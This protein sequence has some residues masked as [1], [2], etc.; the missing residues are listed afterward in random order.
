MREPKF[1][2]TKVKSRPPG[3]KKQ[4]LT[5]SIYYP[6]GQ[7]KFSEEAV[8]K[9]QMEGK[10]IEFYCDVAKKTLAWILFDSINLTNITGKLPKVI[11]RTKAGY[12]IVTAKAIL[13]QLNITQAYKN[14][15]IK[16]Y[17]DT[18]M[19]QD[20]LYVRVRKNRFPL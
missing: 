13:S 16:K 15:P 6:S 2:F 19:R 7:I 3:R 9:Y 4:D 14:L 1:V 8:Q 12:I 10:F 11:K 5:I 20:F 18:M 17:T